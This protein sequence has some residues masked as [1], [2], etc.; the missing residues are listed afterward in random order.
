MTPEWILGY[1]I[2]I[3]I[4][5]SKGLFWIKS[6]PL[7]NIHQNEALDIFEISSKIIRIFFKKMCTSQEK[8]GIIYTS[9]CE[10]QFPRKGGN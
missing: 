2:I 9:G 3:Y 4:F 6:G 7:E 8:Y 5:I 1:Y 10:D